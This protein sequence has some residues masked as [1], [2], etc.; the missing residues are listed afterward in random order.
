[1][2]FQWTGQAMIPTRLEAA[3]KAFVEGQKYWLEETSER[4]WVSHAH[5]FAWIAAAWDNLPEELMEKF[6]TPTHLRRA[7]LIATGWYRET[8]IEAGSKEA[9][10]RV[11]A[12]AKNEDEFSYVIV[13]GPTVFV[14]KAKSQRMHGL[15]RMDK[16]Q[17]QQSKDAI[18][19][20]IAQ[21]IGLAPDELMR[22][23]A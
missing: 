18:L 2:R 4:S 19:G 3:Q 1:M 13:R 17:F 9:A 16:E 15:D 20:W 22:G 11:A 8:L 21:L 23:A 7:A 14:R 5:E 10:R 6:P 12:Y